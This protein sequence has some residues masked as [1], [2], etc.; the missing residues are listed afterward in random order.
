MEHWSNV[1]PALLHYPITPL[2]FLRVLC[3]LC[4]ESEWTNHEKVT[5]PSDLRSHSSRL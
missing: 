1:F 2:L 5:P 4:G 3:D